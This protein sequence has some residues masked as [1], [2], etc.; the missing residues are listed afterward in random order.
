MKRMYASGFDIALLA[1]LVMLVSVAG[2][3]QTQLLPGQVGPSLHLAAAPA[4]GTVYK[5]PAAIENI[6]WQ[7]APTGTV[8]TITCNLEGSIDNVNWYVLD[9]IEDS[10]TQWAG[11]TGEMR[12]VVNKG[13]LYIRTRLVSITGGGSISTSLVIY[14]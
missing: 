10:D 13:L 12:H 1:I 14:Q 2:H 9:Q 3:C 4:T 5:M 7:A 11:S 8:S 6:T